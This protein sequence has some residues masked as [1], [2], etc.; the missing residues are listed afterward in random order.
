MKYGRSLLR[1][2]DVSPTAWVDKWLGYKALKK[3]LKRVV[4]L[5]R[6]QEDSRAQRV[7]TVQKGAMEKDPAEKG[8]RAGTAATTTTTAM[9]T[10]HK[11]PQTMRN[12]PLEKQF[13]ETLKF[14]LRKVTD[15]YISKLAN[16]ERRALPVSG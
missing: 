10:K 13:F 9:R 14:E 2:A 3:L 6:L 1:A 7:K 4:E 8:A 11:G 15:F 12:N 16:L 5:Y